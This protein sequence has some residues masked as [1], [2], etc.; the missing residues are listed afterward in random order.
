MHEFTESPKIQVFVSCYPANPSLPSP[1][2]VM[3]A[4]N[5]DEK[6]NLKLV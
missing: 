4:E 2:L 5:Q 3:S 1:M 6:T